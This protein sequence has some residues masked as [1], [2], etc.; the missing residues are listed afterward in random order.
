[1]EKPK[2]VKITATDHNGG[3]LE[4]FAEDQDRKDPR[5][6][7]NAFIFTDHVKGIR[8]ILPMSSFRIITIAPFGEEDNAKQNP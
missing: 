5:L 3:I 4:F 8:T 2:L 7:G 1:M 6:H